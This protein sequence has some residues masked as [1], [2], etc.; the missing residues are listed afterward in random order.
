MKLKDIADLIGGKI[1][2][3]GDIEINGISGISEAKDGDITFLSGTKLLKELK[4]SG[5][6]AVIVK[7]AVKDI[8]KPQIIVSNPL[9]AFARLL[10]HF[11]VKPHRYKGISEKAFVSEKAV[12]RENVTIYPFAHISDS[13][14]I[15]SGTV[16]YSGVFIGEDT[17]IGND[18][19][20]YSNVTVREGVRIGSRVIIHAGAVIGSDGF[21]YV[22]ED[23]M[24]RKIPQVGG[25]IIEDDVEIGANVTIDRATTGNTIVGKGTKIDNLVQ[26]GHNVH[27]GSNV[28][29]VSQVGI[30][31]SSEIGDGV[32]LGGQV[33]VAD[34]AKLEAGTMVGAKGGAMGE[35]KRSIY[36][37]I[38][39]MPHKDWLKAMAIFSKLPELKKKI[40]ELEE[41][42][43]E[44][45]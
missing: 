17:V 36:S 8:E 32:I 31:G 6:A 11:Y 5:A 20:I 29:L 16:I 23:G 26:I 27:I 10:S 3:S 42:I 25:V 28:I 13:A 18:S 2:G 45:K 24:H 15:G 12:L 44:G 22:F 35:M 30:G 43:K 7:E 9:Y 39:P 1:I 34:H 40:K 4:G 21:G 14:T 38:L 19:V 37:G 41:K 33:G